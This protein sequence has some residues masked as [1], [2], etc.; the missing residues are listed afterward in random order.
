MCSRPSSARST[1]RSSPP[2][3]IR[4]LCRLAEVSTGRRRI[5][6]DRFEVERQRATAPTSSWSVV[7]GVSSFFG[8]KLGRE[9]VSINRTGNKDR[10]NRLSPGAQHAGRELCRNNQRVYAHVKV[11]VKRVAPYSDP[12]NEPNSHEREPSTRRSTAFEAICLTALAVK[13]EDRHPSVRAVADD[14]ARRRSDEPG[15]DDYEPLAMPLARRGHRHTVLPLAASPCSW[16]PLSR[17]RR[18]GAECLSFAPKR[19]SARRPKC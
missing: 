15:S 12:C 8:R 11:A 16:S 3:A 9:L 18:L 14:L 17:R 13:P 19:R 6:T 7:S 4:R 2:R 10:P 5:R 1:V